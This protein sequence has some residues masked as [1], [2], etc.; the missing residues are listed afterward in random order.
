M[1]TRLGAIGVMALGVVVPLLFWVSGG[2]LA[3]ITLR[4]GLAEAAIVLA[5]ATAV[6]VPIYAGLLGA[7]MAVLQ[8]LALVWLPVMALAQI[9]RA[10]V[11][12]A[13]TLQIGTLLAAAGVLAF[14]ALHGD[15]AAFWE[16][17]LQA[18]ADALTGGQP[19][20]EWNQAVSRLAP[21]LTGLWA[22]NLLAVAVLCL[23]LGRWWQAVLYNQGG[24]RS[25]FHGLRFAPWFGALG[26]LAALAAGFAPAGLIADLGVVIAAAF[27]LQ[28]LAVAHAL[29]AA[30]NWHGGWLVGFYL[31][32]PLLLRPIA[33]LGLAD[34]FVDFR[35]RFAPSA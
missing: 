33:L 19:G 7:P 2:V 11:S 6:L 4:R 26:L 1:R 17:T 32:L 28:A 23:L 29:A 9:L 20:P 21:R 25:E 3:L 8:P 30:R 35:A 15:P 22:T 18:I 24:F 34:T 16:G 12:L 10:T 13:A 5:G 31:I 14:Y 27:L